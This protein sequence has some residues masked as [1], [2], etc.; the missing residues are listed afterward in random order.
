MEKKRIFINKYNIEYFTPKM[1]KHL[2]ELNLTHLDLN[3]SDSKNF[4]NQTQFN[5][6]IRILETLLDLESGTISR[7]LK[8]S[9]RPSTMQVNSTSIIKLPY[10]STIKHM[11]SEHTMDFVPLE[12]STDHFLI[13]FK[14]PNIIVTIRTDPINYSFE[15]VSIVMG[16]VQQI[17][18]FSPTTSNLLDQAIIRLIDEIIDDNVEVIRRFRISV[19]FLETIII[20]GVTKN[21]LFD[22]VL[23]LKSVS[24]RLY[25]YI[26]S[27]KRFLTRLYS[28][29]LPL[30][31]LDHD[32]LPILRTTIDEIDSQTVIINDIN[33]MISEIINIYS[34]LIQNRMN[35]VLKILTIWSVIFLLP[36]FIVGFFGMNN[37]AVF[38]INPVFS[39]IIAVILLICIITPLILLWKFKMFRKIGL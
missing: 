25:S 27:E 11:K 29:G 15:C 20:R 3:I 13:L 34:L 31:I 16:W 14:K 33:L 10:F 7:L 4:R 5:R 9:Y 37:F 26:L 17:E 35:N 38:T 23:K 28:A 39:V 21:N 19:E 6:E 22:E 2:K 36:T 32:V 1:I 30:L 12:T 18:K 24:M 8:E